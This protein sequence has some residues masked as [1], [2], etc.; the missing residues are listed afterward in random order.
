MMHGPSLA[1]GGLWVLLVGPVD[2]PDTNASN[3]AVTPPAKVADRIAVSLRR[4]IVSGALRTGDALPS[5]RALA[6]IWDVNRASIREAVRRLES[7]GLVHVRQGSATRV[8]DI[9]LS[10]GLELVPHLF[11]PEAEVDPAILR[12]LHELRA[13]LL[14]WSAE[15]ATMQADPASLARLDE[16]A[17]R[18]AQA[19]TPVERQALDYDFFEALVA[20]GGNRLLQLFAGFVRRIYDTGRARFAYL[21]EGE[22][23]DASHHRRAVEAM[24][25][26]DVTAA[27]AAMRAHAEAA[28]RAVPTST[29]EKPAPRARSRSRR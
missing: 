18:L 19:R 16:L 22:V 1:R 3:N 24:R 25:R 29:A 2:A 7:W 28:L 5:E 27:G 21:Y 12:D 9:F 15:R 4:A 11:E 8:A 20:I 13:M 6:E 17:R 14:G 10:A 23:F 26:R